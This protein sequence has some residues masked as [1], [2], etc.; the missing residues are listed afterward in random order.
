MANAEPYFTPAGE[1]WLALDGDGQGL[2]AVKDD[3]LVRKQIDGLTRAQRRLYDTAHL[4]RYVGTDFL[5]WY[6]RKAD[7]RFYPF[8]EILRLTEAG[9]RALSGKGRG[10]KGKRY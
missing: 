8:G 6:G 10:Q 7:G 5:Q 9:K 3:P 4:S 1:G 2:D